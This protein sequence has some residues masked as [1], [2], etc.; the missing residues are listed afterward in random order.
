VRAY[1]FQ[2]KRIAVS[3]P[4]VHTTTVASDIH[5]LTRRGSIYPEYK[6]ALLN[7]AG[8]RVKFYVG[9]RIADTKN[10]LTYIAS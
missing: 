7:A 6:V 10:K 8:G 9:I 1:G 4:L 5:G 2:T 3:Q